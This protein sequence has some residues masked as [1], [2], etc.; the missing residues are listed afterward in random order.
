M[1]PLFL[2]SPPHV[3]QT[4]AILLSPTNQWVTFCCFFFLPISFLLHT[5]LPIGEF[6]FVVPESCV[7][8]PFVALLRSTKGSFF[9]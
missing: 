3:S 9:I 4:P 2:S 6:N 5:P 7:N 1:F 8:F